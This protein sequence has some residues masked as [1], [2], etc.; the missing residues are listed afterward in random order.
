[1]RQQGYKEQNFC[2]SFTYNFELVSPYTQV[3]IPY[4][5]PKLYFLCSV[6]NAT[7]M[8]LPSWDYP[9]DVLK[10][11]VKELSSYEE[12]ARAAKELPWDEEGYVVRDKFGH[13]VK[14]K[15]PRI[16]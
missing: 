14:I 5:K 11:K 10:P 4:E 9:F 1:M 6:E 12:C 2:R 13:R 8:E 16:C 3:V 15:S 7:L